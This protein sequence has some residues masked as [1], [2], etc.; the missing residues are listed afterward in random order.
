MT[1][2]AILLFTLLAMAM[3]PL[4]YGVAWVFDPKHEF[5]RVLRA[6][7]EVTAGVVSFTIATQE[8]IAEYERLNAAAS[9]QHGGA[10]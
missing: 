8:L 5:W 9:P 1:Q 6:Y 10:N 4:G 2:T 3:A 7:G